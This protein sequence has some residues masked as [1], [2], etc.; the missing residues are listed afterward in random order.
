MLRLY[1]KSR[2]SCITYHVTSIVFHGYRRRRCPRV[3]N[4]N[5]NV[6]SSNICI[7][8]NYTFGDCDISGYLISFSLVTYFNVVNNQPLPIL[9]FSFFFYYRWYLPTVV[10]HVVA[11]G[12]PSPTTDPTLIV[13]MIQASVKQR[14]GLS[15]TLGVLSPLEIKYQKRLLLRCILRNKSLILFLY[16]V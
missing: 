16:F 10:S 6:R 3:K 8:L 5:A 2:D 13:S 4:I 1:N 9:K 7:L 15:V 12:M 14:F 11:W